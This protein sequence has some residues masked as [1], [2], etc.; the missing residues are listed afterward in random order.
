MQTPS[1]ILSPEERHEFELCKQTI[2]DGIQAWYKAAQA[3]SIIQEK[4]LYREDFTSF[5]QFVNLEYKMSRPRAYQLIAAFK[6]MFEIATDQTTVIPE[7]ERIVRDLMKYPKRDRK[8][9]WQIANQK[10]EALK[11]QPTR[12]ML[13]EAAKEVAPLRRDIYDHWIKETFDKIKQ[14]RRL[15][16]FGSDFSQLS[17][18]QLHMFGLEFARIFHRVMAHVHKLR[19]AG[20]KVDLSK[21]PDPSKEEE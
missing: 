16:S 21:N 18:E 14:A 6:V 13:R 1:Y 5:E 20:E 19:E 2:H 10:A 7:G 17:E 8:K 15:L 4:R 12:K 9:I 3:L 11:Q